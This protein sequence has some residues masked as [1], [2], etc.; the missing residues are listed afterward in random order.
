M[1]ALEVSD[2]ISAIEANCIDQLCEVGNMPDGIVRRG[3]DVTWVISGMPSPWMNY[4]LSGDFSKMVLHKKIAETLDHFRSR[5][6]PMTWWVG[7]SSRPRNI[8]GA[9]KA[10]GL[11]DAGQMQ[12]MAVDLKVLKRSGGKMLED[13]TVTQI[14]DMT[15]LENFVDVFVRVFATNDDLSKYLPELFRRMSFGKKT[16]LRHYLGLLHGLPVGTVSL[17][18]DHGVAGIYHVAT[19]PEARRQGVASEMVQT[20]LLDAR[21]AGYRYGVLYASA[22]VAGFYLSMGFEKYFDVLH[23][24][25][26]GKAGEN[27]FRRPGIR[28]ALHFLFGSRGAGDGSR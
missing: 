15:G 7:P 8:G 4:V 14:D 27:V 22:D 9:L 26:D 24:I 12:G 2:L 13:L 23:F 1:K 5:S 16:P 20:A 6:V 28:K 17:R 3:Q 10:C 21:N 18:L 11:R 19:V 25:W